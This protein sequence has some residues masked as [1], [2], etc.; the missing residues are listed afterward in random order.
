MVMTDEEAAKLEGELHAAVAVPIHYMFRGS[1][2]LSYHGTAEG[3]AQSATTLAPH[4]DVRILL[5]GQRLEILHVAEA[6]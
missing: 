4:T 1:T 2:F 3:F 6:R 5:P